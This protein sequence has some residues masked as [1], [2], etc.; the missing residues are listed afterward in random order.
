VYKYSIADSPDFESA[1]SRREAE[2]HASRRRAV[3]N[4]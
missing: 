3:F 1:K 2:I 4:L